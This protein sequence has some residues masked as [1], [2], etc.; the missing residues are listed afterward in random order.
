MPRIAL[1]TCSE[2]P[3]LDVDDQL[4][5]E[6]LRDLGVEAVAAVWD[7]PALDWAAFDLAV[8][9][10]SWDYPRRR[11]EFLAWAQTVPK[12]ANPAK[13]VEWNTDKR[14]LRA[15]SSAGVPVMPTTWLE[16][17]SPVD[18]PTAGEYVVKPAVS[19]GSIDTGRYRLDDPAARELAAAHV[20]RLLDR[21]ATV[22]L[23]PYAAAVDVAGETAMLYVDGRY[24]HAVGK[25][26]MLDGPDPGDGGLYRDEQIQTRQPSAAERQVAEVTL[27]AIP[28]SPDDLLYARVDL[29]P[30]DDGSPIVLEVELTEPSM[31]LA[32]A[33]GSAQRFATAIASRL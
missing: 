13:L 22:M 24:S 33:P 10:S 5:L 32:H 31:F 2:L 9:R 20:E 1:V 23:Q 17:G 27:E 14:Y 12:L 30:A 29:V 11:D 18:L 7:D 28:G 19:A 8:L 16:P 6:P 25:A 26:A 15:L 3:E 4:L 21:R